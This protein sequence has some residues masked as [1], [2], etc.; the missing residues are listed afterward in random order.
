[1]PPMSI[2]QWGDPVIVA[3]QPTRL[4]YDVLWVVVDALR[5]DVAASLHDPIED[6]AKLAA[7]RPPL[8]ALLPSVPGLM[9]NVDRLAGRG[10][11]F[12]H[13][14]SA[15]TWTRAGTLAMLSGERSSELGVDTTNW[16]LS[17][18]AVART[19]ASAPPLLPLVFRRSGAA[20]AA[21]VNNFFLAGYVTVGVDMGFERV[22]DHRYRTRDTAEITR[23]ALGWL[24]AHG[25][26]RFFLFVNYNSP[27]EPYDPPKDKLARVP[28]PPA[29]P[30]DR[31]VRAY[32][33]EAA[34]DDA[35]I[36]EL[37]DRLDALGITQS[38]V[39]V[40]TSDHG[41]TLSAAHD[42]DGLEH[43]PMRFHHAV[44]NFEETTRIPLVMALP[45]VLDGG[46]GDQGPS[47]EYRHRADAPRARR[48]GRRSAAERQVTPAARARAGGAGPR[49]VVVSEGRQ[50]RGILVAELAA[51]R[52]STAVSRTTSSTISTRIRANGT[53][54]SARTRTSSPSC[55]HA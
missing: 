46:R 10:V 5:P 25:H 32:M 28:P 27:H 30:R 50:S 43:M 51:G 3:E 18:D 54:C 2:A 19:Y 20:T 6:A 47:P 8:D 9:P 41:E 14:W 24:D 34:K 13:A 55:A 52:A 36:G 44:G 42:A 7:P 1:M 12:Q 16:I 48:V 29:G 4:P 23:D 45:G 49:A 31:Q 38:T 15:A 35:A 21:F 39:V 33:A 53:T 37:L 40:V 17:A 22:T 11:H 26:D